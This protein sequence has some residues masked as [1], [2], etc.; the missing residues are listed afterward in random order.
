[1]CCTCRWNCTKSLI[2]KLTVEKRVRSFVEVCTFCRAWKNAAKWK[3]S[4]KNQFRYNRERVLQ[5][6][7]NLPKFRT[8]QKHFEQSLFFL[9]PLCDSSCRTES[10]ARRRC[11]SPRYFFRSVEYVRTKS[12]V[13]YF[14]QVFD[15]VCMYSKLLRNFWSLK[16]I[17]AWNAKVQLSRTVTKTRGLLQAQNV[18]KW[19]HAPSF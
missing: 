18:L 7:A 19:K 6:M 3:F 4:L 12:F 15:A 9:R 2:V 1:M 13:R 17:T 11:R 10:P 14:N 8:E 5:N 16:T